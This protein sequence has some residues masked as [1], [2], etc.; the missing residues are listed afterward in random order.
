MAQQMALAHQAANSPESL[1]RARILAKRLR[2]NTQALKALLP[3]RLAQRCLEQAGG[4]QSTIGATRDMTQASTLVANLDADLAIIE[5]L[6][7]V[8]VGAALSAGLIN[9]SRSSPL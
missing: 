7:G 5:F 4:L 9:P 1:H 3:K 2:Y 6:R 8:A